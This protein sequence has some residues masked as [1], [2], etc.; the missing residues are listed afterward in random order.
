[1]PL[2]KNLPS[3]VFDPRSNLYFYSLPYETLCTENYS[4][5]LKMNA[6]TCLHTGLHTL[7]PGL[8]AVNTAEYK[9]FGVEFRNESG[10]ITAKFTLDFLTSA[11]KP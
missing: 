1:V 5:F 8:Q 3:F 2:I 9:H 4:R 11:V 7:L 10:R 6:Q